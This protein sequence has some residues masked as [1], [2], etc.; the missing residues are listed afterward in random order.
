MRNLALTALAA[1]LLISG[2]AWAQDSTIST[3]RTTSPTEDVTPPPMRPAMDHDIRQTR[4]YPEQPPIIPHDIEGYEVTANYN[5]CMSCHA[6]AATGQSQA[7]MVSVTHYVDREGQVLASVSPR[8]YFCSQCHV[9]QRPVEPLV[10][11]TFI[12]IDTLLSM[13]RQ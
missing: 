3:L 5:K 7:P 9:S 2:V 10:T 4:N 13:P 12:D 1:A 8:R 6:R 11:N